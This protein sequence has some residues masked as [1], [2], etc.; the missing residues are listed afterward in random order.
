[1][2]RKRSF[3]RRDGFMNL[4]AI[5]CGLAA[6]IAWR[7]M[8]SDRPVPTSVR[9]TGY[10]FLALAGALVGMLVVALVR[11]LYDTGAR[12]LKQHDLGRFGR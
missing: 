12:Q 10:L 9:F 5:V 2:V 7:L 3:W 6:P 1:M 4:V 8:P 11:M